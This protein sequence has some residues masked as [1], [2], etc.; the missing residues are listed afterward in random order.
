MRGSSPGTGTAGTISAP[1]PDP[2]AG[3]SMAVETAD[4]PTVVRPSEATT[5]HEY[6][7]GDVRP[8]TVIGELVP[9]ADRPGVPS[10]GVHVAVYVSALVAD[11]LCA[12]GSGDEAGR[13]ERD[14]Q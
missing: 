14:G 1:G 5:T 10:L 6:A 3:N 2:L 4:R 8:V 7:P 11:A 9:V 12:D 13:R